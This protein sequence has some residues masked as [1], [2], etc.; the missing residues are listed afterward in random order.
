[1]KPRLW[2]AAEKAVTR[3]GGKLLR[4]GR[5]TDGKDVLFKVNG[6]KHIIEPRGYEHL[7]T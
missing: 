4:I 3:V 1:V 7:K 6:K 5:V 2:S